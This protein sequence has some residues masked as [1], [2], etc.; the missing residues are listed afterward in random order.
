MCECVFVRSVCKHELGVSGCVSQAHPKTLVLGCCL[1][2]C[3]WM[4]SVYVF[5]CVVCVCVF[6][7]VVC[8]YESMC[9]RHCVYGVATISRL[10]KMIDLFFKRAL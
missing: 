3:L 2:M 5:L 8:V 6:L 10:L 9:I 7:C 4:L 1:W